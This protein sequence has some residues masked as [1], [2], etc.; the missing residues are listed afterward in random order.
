MSTLA[1]DVRALMCGKVGALDAARMVSLHLHEMVVVLTS[2]MGE[3]AKV[4]LTHPAWMLLSAVDPR[5]PGRFRKRA[6]RSCEVSGAFATSSG[7]MIWTW[8]LKDR[9]ARIDLI[10]WLIDYRPGARFGRGRLVCR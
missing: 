4:A 9:E 8:Q 6:A 5:L 3:D 7:E 10:G 2:P 1:G